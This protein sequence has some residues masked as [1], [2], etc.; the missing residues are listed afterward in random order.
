MVE[1]TRATLTIDGD[2]DNFAHSR[3]NVVGSGAH[4]V[5]TVRLMGIVNAQ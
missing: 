2:L 1:F 5:P 4:V 3:S